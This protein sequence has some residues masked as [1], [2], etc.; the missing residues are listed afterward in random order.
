LREKVVHGR[1][2]RKFRLQ[3]LSSAMGC[4]TGRTPRA[5]AAGLTKY[6]GIQVLSHVPNLKGDGRAWLTA[7]LTPRIVC[8][9]SD[10]FNHKNLNSSIRAVSP[11][12]L[13]RSD[14]QSQIG[15]RGNSQ[16][17]LPPVSP[18]LL[19]A[20][21]PAA[22]LLAV[23]RA[24]SGSDANGGSELPIRT[25]W[26]F[27]IRSREA[28][29]RV[30][31]TIEMPLE[32]IDLAFPRHYGRA[33]PRSVGGLQ[34]GVRE[35]D[36]T[37]ADR[38]CHT[39]PGWSGKMA[40]RDLVA[41]LTGHGFENGMTWRTYWTCEL[42]CRH[43]PPRGIYCRRTA[44][45]AGGPSRKRGDLALM[46][47]APKSSMSSAEWDCV[48]DVTKRPGGPLVRLQLAF[49]ARKYQN[50]KSKSQAIWRASGSEI[51]HQGKID[52][53]FTLSPLTP[54]KQSVPSI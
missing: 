18:C 20:R 45:Y 15:V 34:A 32:D 21:S 6:P 41:F 44:V 19:K 3:A 14:L 30:G 26:R 48:L 35:Y 49:W 23:V 54:A 4:R 52:G 33:V 25:E 9:T 39:V 53:D 17:A 7:Y 10:T 51:C 12:M 46:I 11:L 28:V 42:R 27:R 16:G 40:T 38:W 2:S 37:T 1:T 5:V 50:R 36:A 43:G 47:S 24:D 8:R 31:Q 29:A 22:A 13:D